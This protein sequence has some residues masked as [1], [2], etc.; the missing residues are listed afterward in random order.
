MDYYVLLFFLWS[1][2]YFFL[3]KKKNSS[4]LEKTQYGGQYISFNYTLLNEKCSILILINAPCPFSIDN[5]IL[6]H[7]YQLSQ[8]LVFNISY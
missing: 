3:E 1:P 8:T 7:S 4:N 5:V 6:Y 2:S